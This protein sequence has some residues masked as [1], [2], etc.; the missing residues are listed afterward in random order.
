MNAYGVTKSNLDY[1]TSS[2]QFQGTRKKDID[3]FVSN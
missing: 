3:E 2:L 1:E